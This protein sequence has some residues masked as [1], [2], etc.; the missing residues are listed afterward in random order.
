MNAK[1]K[2]YKGDT[3]HKYDCE[4]YKNIILILLV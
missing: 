1:F 2:K 4:V 3:K